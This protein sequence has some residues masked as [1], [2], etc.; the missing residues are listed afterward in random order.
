MLLFNQ[1]PFN[2]SNGNHHL[3][4]H[5]LIGISHREHAEPVAVLDS[6]CAAFLCIFFFHLSQSRRRSGFF[7]YYLSAQRWR[8]L[9]AGG[10]VVRFSACGSD[11]LRWKEGCGKSH[12]DRK[13]V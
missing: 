12:L 13:V 5:P 11:V 6:I 3:H 10:G 8:C 2:D 1:R 9:L 4:L 7:G